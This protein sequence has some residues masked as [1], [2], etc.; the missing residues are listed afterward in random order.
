MTK[1][2]RAIALFICIGMIL[3]LFTSFAYILHE[4][5]HNCVGEHCDVCKR[6]EVVKAVLQSFSLLIA[7]VLITSVVLRLHRFLHAMEGLRLH[8]SCTLVSW[9]V[10]LNN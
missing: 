10:R 8:N 1:V 2:K 3:V 7:A 4:A 6:V 5:G 9:K